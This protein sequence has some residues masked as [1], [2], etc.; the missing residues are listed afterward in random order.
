MK[1]I[2]SFFGQINFVRRFIPN[3]AEIV[4]PISKILKKNARINWMA[5]ALEAFTTIK[6]EIKEALVLKSPNFG[7]PFQIFSFA[8]FHTVAAV[9]L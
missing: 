8:S 1:A 5:K 7:K 9:M 3:F 6:K 4:N 2:Q